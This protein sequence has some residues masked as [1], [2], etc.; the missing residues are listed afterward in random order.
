MASRQGLKHGLVVPLVALAVTLVLAIVGG[1][2]GVSFIDQLSG[3]TLPQGAQSSVQQAA[4]EGGLGT[5]LTV[6]GI[7][8]LLFPFIGGAVGGLWGART[9]THRP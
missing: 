5:I 7:L 6:W 3:V 1:L 9:G 2:L 8:A 4:P